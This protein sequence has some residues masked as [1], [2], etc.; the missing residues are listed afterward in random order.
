MHP[1]LVHTTRRSASRWAGLTAR[2]RGSVS[3]W[4]QAA[5]IAVAMGAT[6]IAVK[7]AYRTSRMEEIF[8]TEHN[9]PKK[10]WK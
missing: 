10:P 7:Y 9:N 4:G 3:R 5:R 2:N 6:A 8:T 1:L